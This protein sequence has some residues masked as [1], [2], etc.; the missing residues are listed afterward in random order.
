LG[1][2]GLTD[3]EWMHIRAF[4]IQHCIHLGTNDYNTLR[5]ELDELCFPPQ[6]VL[7]R[8]IQILSG[9]RPQLIDCC[10]NSCIAFTG[11][12]CNYTSCPHCN[13]D[14]YDGQGKS[15]NHYQ[16][17]PLKPRL[18]ALSGGSVSAKL[19]LHRSK[20]HAHVPGII[21]DVFDSSCYRRLRKEHP[22]V[23]GK[24]MPHKYFEDP[25]DIALGLFTDGFRLF[26]R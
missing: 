16:Y 13:K 24:V 23:H 7:R 5:E 1:S 21:T 3:S 26:K 14:W 11:D 19:M 17:L 4:S 12:F 6:K 2:Q 18:Q 20:G 22:I 9:L 10:V 8:R 25:R 15:Q